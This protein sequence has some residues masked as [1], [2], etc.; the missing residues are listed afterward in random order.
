MT[1]PATVHDTVRVRNLRAP[2]AGARGDLAVG[3]QRTVPVRAHR[4]HA[5]ARLGCRQPI[6]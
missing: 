6:L 4:E 5:D 1:Y 3:D 2:V